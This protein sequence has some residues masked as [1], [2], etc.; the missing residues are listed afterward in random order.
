MKQFDD[1][2]LKQAGIRMI[3]TGDVVDDDMLESMGAPALGVVTSF[4]YSAA[5]DRPRTRR[6]S[7]RS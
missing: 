1:R 3:G 2:G 4:H 5:H 6:T 7:T